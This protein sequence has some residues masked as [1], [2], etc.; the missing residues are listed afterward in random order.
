MC[1]FLGFENKAGEKKDLS[2]YASILRHRGPDGTG[3]YQDDSFSFIHW[4]LSV[5]DLSE[6]ASQPFFYENWVLVFNGEIYNYREVAA[7]LRQKGYHFTTESD[8]EVLIKA[9]HCWQEQ[10]VDHFI[11][12]FA[13]AVYN[14]Q[15][16]EIF[17][18]RDRM[19][20][21]P[22]YYTPD[23]DFAFGSEMKIFKALGRPLSIDP[24][25]VHQYFRFGY[26]PGE[27]TI[28]REIR[29][30]LPGHYIRFSK[31]S[32]EIKSYWTI[33]RPDSYPEMNEEESLRLLESTLLSSF[34]Y[35]M[36]SDVPVGIFLSGGID[37]S[38]VATLLQKS[39]SQQL[40]TFTIGFDHTDF[41]ETLYARRVAQR[42]GTDHIELKL[43][44][45]R[46]R[47]LFHNFYE[48]YDEP[49]S[50]TSGIPVALVAALA[51]EHGVKVVLSA[52]GADELFGGYPHY[53]RVNANYTG[54]MRI[55]A[56]VRKVAAGCIH[57]LLP[58]NIR[59]KLVP[60]N[61]EHRMA[62]SE[63]RL[64]ASDI[65]GLFES[66]CSN[67]THEEI[68]LLTGQACRPGALLHD[69]LPIDPRELMMQ[70][71]AK[72][73]LPDDLLMKVD[74]ATMHNSIEGRDPF[75]DHRIVE[76]ATKLPMKLKIKDGK[77]KVALRKI[78]LRYHP[79]S[80]FERPKQGF[81]IPIFTWFKNDLDNLFD[82]YLTG[83][84]VEEAGL[85]QEEVRRELQKYNYYK[86]RDRQY[87]VEKMW[88]LL[89]F[90]MWFNR[91]MR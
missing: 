28:F 65:I 5:I 72:F 43:D 37:S 73:Y 48:I 49:F 75:L 24:A 84:L 81:S 58:R 76:L 17:L 42:L 26:I 80:L 85:N 6:H 27:K 38:L 59:S 70:W 88:R 50:D 15:N 3:F 32:I 60:Y 89:S 66:S 62:A 35:R 7:E 56:F 68:E 19:G 11:G 1:G 52:D 36:V 77:T 61:L 83:N 53:Q 86:G 9:F 46:A 63:E 30:L 44:V 67:Q 34:Q 40:K 78:L 2:E 18:F 4:R 55:P 20:V 33:P 90:M 22:L 29:K 71:D 54:L 87:N 10:A 91:W 21:K 64:R 57:T 51:R 39:S 74:R 45:S 69:D 8:S 12:M 41:D 82:R 16:Q 47:E 14:R 25:A 23:K 31:G 79:A 13:F